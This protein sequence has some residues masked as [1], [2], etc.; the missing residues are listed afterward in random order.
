MFEDERVRLT[1]P[2]LRVLKRLAA[3]DT[4]QAIAE[5]LHLSCATV[6]FH[7]ARLQKRIGV[8]NNTALVAVA[9]IAGLLSVDGWPPQLTGLTDIDLHH[10]TR[11]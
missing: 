5:E 1:T 6:A 8:S 3:G 10:L 11:P 4:Y 9:L 2:Q 7:A